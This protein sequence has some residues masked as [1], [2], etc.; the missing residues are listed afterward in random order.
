MVGVH[1][2]IPTPALP[3]KGREEV[4]RALPLSKG[5]PSLRNIKGW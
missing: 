1:E 3:L 5:I 4:R 2:P